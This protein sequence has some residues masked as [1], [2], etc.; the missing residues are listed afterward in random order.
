LGSSRSR[1]GKEI[2]LPAERKKDEGKG[3]AWEYRVVF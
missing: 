3:V 2:E 1:G